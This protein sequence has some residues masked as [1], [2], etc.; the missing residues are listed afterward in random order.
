MVNPTT[1]PDDDSL[2]DHCTFRELEPN[3]ITN[4][5]PLGK[6][7]GGF[8]LPTN[9]DYLCKLVLAQASRRKTFLS[10]CWDL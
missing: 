2:L 5:C 1:H 7:V 3:G 8:D 6:A 10:W 4:L 9:S